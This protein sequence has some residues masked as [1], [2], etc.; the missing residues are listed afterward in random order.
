M[1]MCV[2]VCLR[3][4]GTFLTASSVAKNDL[5][6]FFFSTFSPNKLKMLNVSLLNG[7]LF[8][9]T[10]DLSF[11]NKTL[12]GVGKPAA[13]AAAHGKSLDMIVTHRNFPLGRT[14]FWSLGSESSRVIAPWNQDI[15][16]CAVV[17]INFSSLGRWLIIACSRAAPCRQ[18]WSYNEAKI[19]TQGQKTSHNVGNGNPEGDQ[20]GRSSPSQHFCWCFHGSRQSSRWDIWKRKKV[21]SQRIAESCMRKNSSWGLVV[22]VWIFSN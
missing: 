16:S 9:R 4:G 7:C 6:I 5:S 22:S 15:F 8:F 13:L 19:R 18:M 17:A 3:G 10:V 12:T 20:Q 2:C 11:C 21:L 1:Y 14:P